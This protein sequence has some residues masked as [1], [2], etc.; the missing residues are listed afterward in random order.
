MPLSVPEKPF[1][2]IVSADEEQFHSIPRNPAE[3][4][5]VADAAPRLPDSMLQWFESQSVGQYAGV[6]CFRQLHKGVICP[7]L[8]LPGSASAVPSRDRPS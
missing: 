1:D 5:P 4:N 8:P 3:E 2:L 6:K 7:A